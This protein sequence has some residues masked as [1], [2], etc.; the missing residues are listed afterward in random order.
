M[1]DVHYTAFSFKKQE[2]FVKMHILPSFLLYKITITGLRGAKMIKLHKCF[3]YKHSQI[4]NP[5]ANMIPKIIQGIHRVPKGR[6]TRGCP[7]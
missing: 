5:V 7:Q 1:I 6:L 4:S 2:E 3:P